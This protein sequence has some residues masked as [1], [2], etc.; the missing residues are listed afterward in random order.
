M[1][2]F[3]GS[4]RSGNSVIVL[5]YLMVIKW[6][7]QPPTSHPYMCSPRREAIGADTSQLSTPGHLAH[8]VISFPEVPRTFPLTSQ[9][10]ELCHMAI[11]SCKGS[12]ESKYLAWGCGHDWVRPVTVHLCG[13]W[14]TK[15]FEGWG[16]L[17]DNENGERS[18]IQNNMKG[19]AK[20][21]P[22]SKV[23]RGQKTGKIEACGSLKAASLSPS[24]IDI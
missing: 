10:P 6:L 4:Q 12:W 15:L 22:D 3:S 13:F 11:S 14:K 7:S 18:Y 21:S 1:G 19:K 2:S 9:W 23:V 20:R 5:A 24:P 8:G 17:E 16:T